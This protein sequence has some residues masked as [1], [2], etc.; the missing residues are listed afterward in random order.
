M[1]AWDVTYKSQDKQKAPA[2]TPQITYHVSPTLEEETADRI[3][4]QFDFA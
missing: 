4:L 2:V 3:G 1:P